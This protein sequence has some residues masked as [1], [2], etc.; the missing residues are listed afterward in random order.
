[1]I[2]RE[3]ETLCLQGNSNPCFYIVKKG[4]LIASFKD[5]QNSIRTQ[6]LGP[7]STFGELS[8]VEGEPMEYTIQAD[9]DSEIEVIQQAMLHEAMDVQPVWMK[10]ILAFLVQRN[11]IAK[12]NKRKNDFITTFPALL[13]ILSKINERTINLDVIKNELKNF[14]TLSSIETY[15]L[16]LILQDFRLIRLQAETVS[17]DNKPLINVLYETLRHRAIYKSTSPNILSLTEQAILTAFAKAATDKGEL[18]SDGRIAVKADDLTAQTKRSMHGMSLTPRSLE[19]LLQKQLLTA[20][21]ED[22]FSADFDTL[23]NL[24]ELN[25]IYPKLDKKLLEV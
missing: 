20:L 1:M 10:S 25:R 11:H 21:P 2:I 9:Q 16:L 19:T 7:G 8:L 5:E 6:N 14:S 18:Q 15:K 24:L 3:G 23:L 12:E 13:F 4:M 22:K 17:I